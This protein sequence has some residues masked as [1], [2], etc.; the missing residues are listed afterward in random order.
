[1]QFNGTYTIEN[2]ESGEHRTFRVRTQKDD[3]RFAPGRRIIGLLTG[4]DNNHSYTNFGFV[5]DD[6]IVVWMK[7]R[8]TDSWSAY[9]W[10]AFML[11][12]L[13]VNNGTELR[14]RG[15]AYTL[16][17]EKH[18]RICNRKLT[19]PESIRS[20]IGPVCAGRLT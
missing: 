11:W 6:G 8:G 3:A 2:T 18:C 4:P 1:M 19:T 17:I 20:G 7:K 10:Y 12:D 9:Q 14:K 5:N 13:A 16:L 15:K